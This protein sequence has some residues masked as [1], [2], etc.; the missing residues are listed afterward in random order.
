SRARLARLSL[1]SVPLR[2]C[3]P[4][5]P[6]PPRRLLPSRLPFRFLHPARAPAELYPLSLH[7]ALPISSR[8]LLDGGRGAPAPRVRGEQVRHRSEEHT[9][10]LQSRRDLV[11]RLLLEKK[12]GRASRY[13][14]QRIAALTA[15]GVS[16]RG[17][18]AVG[19]AG[20]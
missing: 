17:G 11:C 10:E 19:L 15:G 6:P 13:L 18:D 20:P 12:N 9:S 5:A 3:S 1:R 7:D 14:R 4:P 16:E 8:S 2:A